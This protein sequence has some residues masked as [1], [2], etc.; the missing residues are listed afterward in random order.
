MV[1]AHGGPTAAIVVTGDEAAA[2]A[3]LFTKK[4]GS[5]SGKKPDS[6]EAGGAG[7]WT[8]V[9]GY[10][11]SEWKERNAQIVAFANVNLQTRAFNAWKEA[12]RARAPVT[13]DKSASETTTPPPKRGPERALSSAH[14]SLNAARLDNLLEQVVFKKVLFDPYMRQAARHDSNVSKERAFGV[15]SKKNKAAED[16]PRRREPRPADLHQ[17]QLVGRSWLAPS[18][19]R[20]G[21]TGRKPGAASAAGGVARRVALDESVA[22]AMRLT[23]PLAR[24]SRPPGRAWEM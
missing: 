16:T 20:G 4:G 14:K 22:N 2:L 1:S 5:P 18:G 6:P 23:V 17:G 11:A 9:K 12:H 21:R 13:D 7:A 24:V 19:A 15:W 8:A 3:D 10:S